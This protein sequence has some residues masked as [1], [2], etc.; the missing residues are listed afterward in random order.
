MSAVPRF[1]GQ[2]F[3]EL[4]TE[5]DEAIQPLVAMLCEFHPEVSRDAA[6]EYLRMAYAFGRYDGIAATRRAP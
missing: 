1:I 3:S 6:L 5:R 2:G 4:Q